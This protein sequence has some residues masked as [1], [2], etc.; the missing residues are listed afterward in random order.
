MWEAGEARVIY[1]KLD[2]GAS[3][4]FK[5]SQTRH[6]LCETVAWSIRLASA[7]SA[8]GHAMTAPGHAPTA[9]RL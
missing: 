8:L 9:G 5:P 2:C 6:M 4:A 3:S 1:N 7:I